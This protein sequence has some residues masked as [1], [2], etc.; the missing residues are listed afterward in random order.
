MTQ[1]KLKGQYE[2][3]H[4]RRYPHLPSLNCILDFY[5]TLVPRFIY[6]Y[7]TICSKNIIPYCC[8]LRYLTPASVSKFLDSCF[9]M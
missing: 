2:C 1:Q 6:A 4:D 3:F 8:S 9:T 5:Y 7:S